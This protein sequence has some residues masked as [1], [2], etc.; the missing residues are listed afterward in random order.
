M[1]TGKIHYRF[2]STVWQYQGE[3]GW[4]FVTLPKNVSKEIRQLF[5]KQEE[6]WGR[7]KVVA[8]IGESK[9]KTAI[10]YDTK[11]QAYVL[12]LKKEVRKKE[13]IEVNKSLDIT[14]YI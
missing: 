1:T 9:W 7:L 3:G 13:K 14:I 8:L 2:N 12:P 11:Y 6:G 10:W 5:Q 4:H